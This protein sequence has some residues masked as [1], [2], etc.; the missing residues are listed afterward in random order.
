MAW[1]ARLGLKRLESVWMQC[2]DPRLNG[3]G[4]P[5]GFETTC[6]TTVALVEGKQELSLPGSATS[7]QAAS[8]DGLATSRQSALRPRRSAPG[9]VPDANCSCDCECVDAPA[10]LHWAP[11]PPHDGQ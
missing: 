6:S 9:S 10:R 1:E 2:P 5:F 11:A 4:S 7:K 3:L 8:S